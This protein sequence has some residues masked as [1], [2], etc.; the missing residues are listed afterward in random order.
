MNMITM[1]ILAICHICTII[2]SWYVPFSWKFTSIV[3]QISDEFYRFPLL[4]YINAL[5]RP[6]IYSFGYINFFSYKEYKLY[7][8][9]LDGLVERKYGDF[10]I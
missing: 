6:R 5:T 7:S 9:Y 4:I 10:I 3:Y 2:P 8:F 1:V